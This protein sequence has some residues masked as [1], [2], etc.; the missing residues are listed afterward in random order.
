VAR[1]QEVSADAAR[2]MM[3]ARGLD[4][5]LEERRDAVEGLAG[6]I[7]TA[8]GASLRGSGADA[9]AIHVYVNPGADAN[10]VRAEAERLL[11][12]ASVEVIETEMPQAQPD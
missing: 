3:P 8:V 1:A 6:V 10:R 9:L 2:V 5:L 12:G 7:G 4:E 11:E